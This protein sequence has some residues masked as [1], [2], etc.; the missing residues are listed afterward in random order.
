MK[1]MI[2]TASTGGG[3]NAAA[4]AVAEALQRQG[5]ETAVRDCMAVAGKQFSQRVSDAY[6]HLV[7]SSPS[8]FGRIYRLGSTVS[9]WGHMSPIYLANA[10]YASKM[11]ALLDAEKPD[12][13]ICTHLFAG[14]TLTYLR[15]H[16][17]YT[18]LTAFVMTDYTC[19]PFQREVQCDLLFISHPDVEAEC[20]ADGMDSSS[21]RTFG[22][23]VSAACRPC[24]NKAEAKRTAGLSPQCREVLLAGGSMGAGNLPEVIDELLPALGNDGHITAVCGSNAHAREAAEEKFAKNG[25]VTVLGEVRPLTGLMAACDVLVSKSG[26]LTSTEAMAMNLP[27]VVYHALDG[28]EALNAALFERNG[29]AMW[30]KDAEELR[31]CVS[32]L[33]CDESA[34]NAMMSRQRLHIDPCAADRIAQELLCAKEMRD[35][36]T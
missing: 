21:F 19:I 29:M 18:G 7:Q 23:P 10:S 20:L 34:R 2:F 35:H 25:Q 15:K 27:F 11:K 16:G 12:M 26:G 14:H 6:V 13:V 31:A 33:L 22:I 4:H 17:G 24:S 36:E 9:D 8:T 28:C 5:V 3:H 30:A 1:A 32:R